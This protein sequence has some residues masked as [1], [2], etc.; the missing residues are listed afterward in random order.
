MLVSVQRMSSKAVWLLITTTHRG[1]FL[2]LQNKRFLAVSLAV[3]AGV[4]VYVSMVEIFFK[5]L[6]ALSDEW[7]P[8]RGVGD[9]C[10]KAYGVTTAFFFCGL[11]LC[12]ALNVFT[13]NLE[14]LIPL[15]CCCLLK[16]NK[17]EE[18]DS[19][20]DEGMAAAEEGMADQTSNSA[21]PILHARQQLSFAEADPVKLPQGWK[22]ELSRS[23]GKPFFYNTVTGV[24]Q[25]EMPAE[26]DQEMV[27]I[28]V[29]ST[30]MIASGAAADMSSVP[31]HICACSAERIVPQDDNAVSESLVAKKLAERKQLVSTGLL[32]GIAIAIHNFPEGLATFVAAM[33]DPSLGGAIAVAI[34]IHNIPEGVCVAMPVYYATK[35]K[36]KAFFWAT[37]SGVS[38][39]VGALF[40]YA[41]LHGNVSNIAYGFMFGIV[42]GMMVYI[43]LAELL[44]AAYRHDHNPVCVCVCVCLHVPSSLLDTCCAE[45]ACVYMLCGACVYICV[46]CVCICMCVCVCVCVCVCP[47]RYATIDTCC[48][49]RVCIFM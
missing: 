42:A 33:A 30:T 31:T 25:W 28:E 7:C 40:G 12:A 21:A 6:R 32:T 19:Q 26:C 45:H 46:V 24:I 43:S 37:L 17:Q 36:F 49:V 1:I 9:V 27:A 11:A 23:M 16:A 14:H 8:N 35:S 41:V 47:P 3:A 34:A 39:P 29:P 22:L 48:V 10:P 15:F 38:E 20:E 2:V 5:S 13:H 44:P 18:A 4:M